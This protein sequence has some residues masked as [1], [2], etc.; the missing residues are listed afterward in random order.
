[1]PDNSLFPAPIDMK[2]MQNEQLAQV[3]DMWRLAGAITAKSIVDDRLIDLP[4]N[5]LFW[6]LALGKKTS[7]FDLERIEPEMYKNLA[8]FQRMANRRKEILKR[9]HDPEKCQRQLEGLTTM[10]GGK[11]EDYE[12]TFST[13]FTI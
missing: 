5:S 7:L 6:D 9:C 3:Y 2:K 13:S 4:F 1:M 11:I 8:D 10:H 12:L